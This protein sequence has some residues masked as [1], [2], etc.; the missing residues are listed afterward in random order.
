M[1]FQVDAQGAIHAR[2]YDTEGHIIHWLR[3]W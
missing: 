3:R 1:G 2:R